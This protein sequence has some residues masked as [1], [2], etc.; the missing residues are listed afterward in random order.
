MAGYL[1]KYVGKYRVKA[2]YDMVTKDFPR[3]EDGRL[4]PS[5]DDLYIDCANKI[6]IKHHGGNVLCCYIPAKQRGMNVLKRIYQEKVSKT[7]PVETTSDNKRYLENLCRELV[8]KEVLVSAEVLDFEVIFEFK[9]D[10]IEYIAKLVGAKTN[11]A[12]ISPFSTKNLPREPYKIPD[13]DMKL[14]KESI[15]DFPTVTR[16]MGKGPIEVPDGLLIKR[17][18]KQFDEIIAATQKPDFDVDQDRR[19]KGLK[20]KEYIHQ[21]GM[22]Q[23][24]CDY[25]KTFNKE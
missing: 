7:L 23:E 21:M 3:L 11:G 10:M 18:N 20:P 24:Y 8:E 14:Y 22:W 5:F 19:T 25:L 13:K 12:N 6:Q 16:D 2:E 9:A 4:D 17:L 1:R 15:K